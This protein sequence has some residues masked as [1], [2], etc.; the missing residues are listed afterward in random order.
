VNGIVVDTHQHFW[1]LD[2]SRYGWMGPGAALWRNIEPPDLLPHLRKA[3]IDRTVA[4]QAE[5]SDADTDYL[6]ELAERWPFIGGVVGWVPLD[7]PDAA[8]RRLEGLT[9]HAKFRG[10]RHWG[11]TVADPDWLVR[12]RV[13]EGLRV[14]AGFHLPFDVVAVFPDHL[15][16][17]PTLAERVPGLTLVLNHLAKPPIRTRGWE[18]WAGQLKAAA[19]YPQVFAKVSGLTTAADPERWTAGDLQPYV[20]WA[21][22]CFGP[23]RLMFGS[24]WPVSEAAGDYARMWAATQAVLGGL[25]PDGRAHVLGGTAER[26]YG[27]MP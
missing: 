24:D 1:N 5:A 17:L 15:R 6:L 13:I 23:E 22:E 9:R 21:I 2:R 10:V 14:L 7:R 4:V 19:Q 11:H 16:H 18:P 3:G 27:P 25:E 12:D 20:D 26:V 8:Q